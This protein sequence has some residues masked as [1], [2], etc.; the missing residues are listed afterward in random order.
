MPPVLSVLAAMLAAQL[1]VSLA[2]TATPVLAPLAA[3]DV[4]VAPHLVGYYVSIVYGVAAIVGAS[5][6]AFILRYGAVR[7]SQA[8]LGFSALSML[9][10][11]TG[12]VYL[13]P[14]AAIAM[15]MAYGPA[16]PASSQLLAVHSPREWMSFVFSIKQ[17]GVPMGNALAGAIL[18]GAALIAGW[19]GAAAGAAA[20]CVGLALALQPMREQFD[21]QRQTRAPIRLRAAILGPLALVWREPAIRRLTLVSVGY[22]GMQVSMGTFL[23]VYLHNHLG[24]DVVSA[25]LALA[26][27]Q[28]GGV[29]GR[30][31]WG[32]VADRWGDPVRLLGALGLIM[33]AAAVCTAFFTAAWPWVL[34]MAVCVVFGATAVGWTGVFLAHVARLAP[35]GRAAELTGGTTFF[36]YGGILFAPSAVSAVLSLGAPYA[37]GFLV[38]AAATLAGGIACLR[39][40]SS[41]SGGG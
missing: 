21:A 27:A 28:A 12:Q 3:V 24:I 36:T 32:L 16:T 17:T 29:V 5:S 39:L 10:L 33:S 14:F 35:A 22:A 19:R 13:L 15:G 11:M 18:P 41:T 6:G 26:A 7:V 9:L 23:V 20:C 8:C 25:G 40:A 4:G 37:L 30:I 31:L 34:V 2:S 1:L 38:L